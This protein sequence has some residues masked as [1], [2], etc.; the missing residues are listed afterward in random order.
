MA[1]QIQQFETVHGNISQS[2]NDTAEA[3]INKSLFLISVGSN[4][5]L[6]FFYF[7]L[8]NNHN[9]SDASLKLNK[10]S[11]M[12]RT[13]YI[14][15]LK[16]LLNLGARKFGVLSVP[17]IGCVP[18]ATNGSGYCVKELNSFAGFFYIMLDGVLQGLK[19]EFPDMKYSLGN[20]YDITYSITNNPSSL[21]ETQIGH[22]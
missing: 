8:S 2:L 10:F 20:S 1:E 16:N 5:I 9:F 11:S 18:I 6:E 3:T 15:H 4:D 17:A 22:G 19:S 7:N 21:V 14:S 13:T 12:L